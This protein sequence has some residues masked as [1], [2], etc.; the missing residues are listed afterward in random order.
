MTYNQCLVKNRF[1]CKL[2]LKVCKDQFACQGD[3]YMNKI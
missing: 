3:F 2:N 1:Y